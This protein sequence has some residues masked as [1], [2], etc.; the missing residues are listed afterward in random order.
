MRLASKKKKKRHWHGLGTFSVPDIVN[1]TLASSSQAL[2]VC[3]SKACFLGGI[4]C[5]PLN[6][7]SA[8][9]T[10]QFFA[11]FLYHCPH[12]TARH[13]EKD[14]FG[15]NSKVERRLFHMS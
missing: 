9:R 1:L 7:Y 8:L 14:M 10:D 12:Q 5:G 6:Q 2:I 3:S 15:T 13:R 4:D 11:L